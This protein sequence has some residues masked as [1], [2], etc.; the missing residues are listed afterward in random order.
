MRG[1]SRVLSILLCA[2]NIREGGE[3]SLNR[4]Q[5]AYNNHLFFREPEMYHCMLLVE[6]FHV[7][8]KLA[9]TFC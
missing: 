3:N 8:L 5:W 9:N 6:R 2:Y 1:R 4:K 7:C